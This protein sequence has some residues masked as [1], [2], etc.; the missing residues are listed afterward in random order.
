MEDEMIQSSA[1]VLVLFGG[2]VSW[3]C[4]GSDRPAGDAS[5]VN[6]PTNTGPDI[7]TGPGAGE[8]TDATP[9]TSNTGAKPDTTD[10]RSTGSAGP[11]MGAGSATP[12]AS[13]V[14]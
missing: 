7:T 9:D 14:H 10:N 8:P 4:G 13:P 1:L 11:D 12:S 3:G 6:S 2:M 5:S